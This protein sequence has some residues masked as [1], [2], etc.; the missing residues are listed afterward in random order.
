MAEWSRCEPELVLSAV[1][2]KK[3]AGILIGAYTEHLLGTSH[4]SAAVKSWDSHHIA[5]GDGVVVC[6]F[7]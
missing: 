6:V 4:T 2:F 5:R 7:Y 1:I 3:Y